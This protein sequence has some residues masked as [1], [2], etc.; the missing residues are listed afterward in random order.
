M[1]I[2]VTVQV[3]NNTLKILSPRRVKI[4]L[5][6]FGLQ[7][8]IS[9]ILYCKHTLLVVLY[10]QRKYC[11]ILATKVDKLRA[12]INSMVAKKLLIALPTNKLFEI[13]LDIFIIFY[14]ITHLIYGE[15]E[16]LI[17][18]V[19]LFLNQPRSVCL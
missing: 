14:T 10:N 9:H 16:G 13:N 17:L 19:K 7:S 2:Y 12:R 6:Q 8:T 4:Y 5:F 1:V 18:K 15:V 3:Q 11:R